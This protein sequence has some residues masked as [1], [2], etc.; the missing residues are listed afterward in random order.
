[1]RR[2][3]VRGSMPH[4]AY[5]C[6]SS[7]PIPTPSV[8]RPG[9]SSSRSAIWRATRVGCRNGSRYTATDTGIVGCTAAS[10]VAL[11]SPSNPAPTKKLT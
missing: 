5:S 9:A 8:S 1:M 4:T 3:R 6:G 2:P 7:P 11:T 10:A